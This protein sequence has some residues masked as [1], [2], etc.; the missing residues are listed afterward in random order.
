MRRSGDKYSSQV[1]FLTPST[2]IR[3]VQ[4]TA[5]PQG[6]EEGKGVDEETKQPAN[7]QEPACHLTFRYSTV[8]NVKGF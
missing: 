6:V 1:L 8:G 5:G 3:S 4:V 7:H 2:I